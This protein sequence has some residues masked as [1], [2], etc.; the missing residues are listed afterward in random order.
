MGSENT[1]TE[2]LSYA[3]ELVNML[4]MKYDLAGAIDEVEIEILDQSMVQSRCKLKFSP[5]QASQARKTV[6]FD[7]LVAV[8]KRSKWPP[9]VSEKYL[10]STL[11]LI[12]SNGALNL[13]GQES[14][15]AIVGRLPICYDWP[16]SIISSLGARQDDPNDKGELFWLV[17]GI[18][19]IDTRLK[20]AF[21]THYDVKSAL[22]TVPN[23]DECQP[24][25]SAQT[26]NGLCRI[27]S[28][29]Q[30]PKEAERIAR[31][32]VAVDSSG[33]YDIYRDGDS[34]TL[35]L[36]ITDRTKLASE[37][38][39][40]L[41]NGVRPQSNSVNYL[42]KLV[43]N[44][45]PK[46]RRDSGIQRLIVAGNMPTPQRSRPD[47]E[48]LVASKNDLMRLLPTV[49]VVFVQSINTSLV[50]TA[51]LHACKIL[52]LRTKVV[53]YGVQ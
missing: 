36:R 7:S 9:D 46:H 45:W 6:V 39:R 15:S 47:D 19:T 5:L 4:D 53:G 42:M 2:R 14:S 48:A 8:F 1:T 25:G 18:R 31:E 12:A 23:Y 34:T 52:G 21:E 41:F 35:S 50:N 38:G 49:E 51:F 24:S 13:Q 27:V 29:V 3:T 16:A 28:F 26:P 37:L 44:Q 11:R 40:A 32:I 43:L 22:L 30:S 33:C 17:P 20:R 10:Q